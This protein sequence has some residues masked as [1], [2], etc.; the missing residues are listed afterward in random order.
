MNDKSVIHKSVGL[1]LTEHQKVNYRFLCSHE[2]IRNLLEVNAQLTCRITLKPTG[3]AR[4]GKA[5]LKGLCIP[6]MTGYI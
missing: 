5:S 6:A 3:I 4:P 1:H 2:A